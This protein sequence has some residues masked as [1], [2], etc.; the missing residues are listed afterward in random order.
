M[1]QA[2]IRSLFP[3]TITLFVAIAFSVPNQLNGQ[4]DTIFNTIELDG[5]VISAVENGFNVESFMHH[6]RTDSSFHKAFLNTKFYPN[7]VK[8]ELVVRNKGDK[9]TAKVE[10]AGRLVRSGKMANWVQESY[11]ETGKLKDRKGEWRY[12]TAEMY[13]DVFFPKGEYVANNSVKDR[14]NEIVR[15]DRF[16]KYKSELKKFMFD[17]G[18]EIASVPFIGDKLA[19]FEPDMARF[20]DFALR[21][22]DRNGHSCWVFSAVAKPEFR[23][24]R[25]VIKNMETWF[26]QETNDVIARQYRITHAS[27]ILDFDIAIKVE[28]AVVGNALVPTRVDYSGVWDIPFKKIEIVRFWLAYSDWDTGL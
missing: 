9:E 15:G 18:S 26:D 25:T 7:R 12:L 20:Y 13:D 28:N 24:G 3:G 22:E 10:R 8:S 14:K 5:V 19:L 23:D 4:V 16:E 21:G 2:L 1:I 11:V 17:P 6:V 27:L